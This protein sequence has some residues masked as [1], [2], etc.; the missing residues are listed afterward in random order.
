MPP[1]PVAGALPSRQV[2]AGPD[3]SPFRRLARTH[4]LMT[5][6]DVAMVVSLAGSL[7]FSIS[8][9]AARSKVLL[10]LLVSF[11]PFAIVAPFIGPFIDR[12]PGGRR[13]IIQLTAVGRALLFVDHDL[14]SRRPVAVPV[15]VR[16][17]DPAE[18]VR[19]FAFGTDPD[20]RQQQDRT[21]R[22]QLQARVDLRC[23]RRA[24]RGTRRSAG[25]DLAEAVVAVRHR[26]V[27]CA[28]WLPR[29]DCRVVSSRSR[30]SRPNAWSCATPRCGRPPWR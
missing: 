3:V 9:D 8:P 1:C 15:V 19:R 2:P 20:G 13:L 10:Y 18:D 23:G 5:A 17:D 12:A 14:P 21:G 7:F 16:R 30:R 22:G 28:P 4:A 6:G 25:G 27:R 26:D 24:R 29:R 11:A